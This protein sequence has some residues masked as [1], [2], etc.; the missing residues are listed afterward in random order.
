MT[1]L[2]NPTDPGRTPSRP[3]N[4]ALA[5]S[6]GRTQSCPMTAPS[7]PTDPDRTPSRPSNYW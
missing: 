7:N 1:A 6:T 4:A 5:P 2:S 3:I